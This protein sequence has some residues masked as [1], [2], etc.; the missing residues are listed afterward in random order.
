MAQVL[1]EH[2]SRYGRN[3]YAR[4]DYEGI[5][6]AAAE[7]LVDALRSRLPQ[8]AGQRFGTVKAAGDGAVSLRQGLRVMFESGSRVVRRLSCAGALDATLRL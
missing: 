5:Q 4:H 2:W 8:L 6:S 7:V 1:D 3:Y